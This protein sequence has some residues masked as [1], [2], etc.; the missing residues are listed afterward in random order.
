MDFP[1]AW[2]EN[3]I[4]HGFYVPS[5]M[6]RCWAASM[7]IVLEIDRICARHGICWW[8]AYGA[9]IGAVRHQGPIPW[10]D[11]MD[12]LIRRADMERLLAVTETELPE[13]WSWRDPKKVRHALETWK[14]TDHAEVY[15]SDPRER[16]HGFPFFALVDF[17][18]L[19]P[20]LPDEQEEK[21]RESL[22]NA[23]QQCLVALRE[24][25]E[26]D[27]PVLRE[28]VRQLEQGGLLPPGTEEDLWDRLYD[29]LDQLCIYPALTG[30]D[31][32]RAEEIGVFPYY[33]MFG[34]NR[35][36]R[37]W[38][39]GSTT[40][41]YL[42][43]DLPAPSG[44]DA[45]LRRRYGDY[46]RPSFRGNAH[47]YPYYGGIEEG[48]EKVFG[49]RWIWH[50]T[51]SPDHL[52]NEGRDAWKGPR[53][54]AREALLGLERIQGML[55]DAIASGDPATI[56]DALGM[57]QDLAVKAGTILEDA[58]SRETVARIEA[59][60][61]SVYRLYVHLLGDPEAV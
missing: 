60:C 27:R 52:C 12:V 53:E 35:Y 17:S 47:G 19:D 15:V 46:M 21:D 45:I 29:L 37:A 13:G 58:G 54:Q 2:F 25:Q 14:L 57:C 16:S 9:L 44:Y 42:G 10:D 38:F 55:P 43:K 59:Y 1:K 36:Q 6:K 22:T 30:P 40:V 31:R 3:E 8:I 33:I 7:E 49:E 56:A 34:T 23:V 41:T 11:D 48:A 39:D 18:I 4:Q 61:E 50:Y 20:F 5:L 24:D 32:D 26:A 51:F 28:I